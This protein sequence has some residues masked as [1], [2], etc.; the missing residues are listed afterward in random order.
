MNFKEIKKKK[1]QLK[2]VEL[3]ITVSEISDIG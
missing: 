3:E 2:N 1:K